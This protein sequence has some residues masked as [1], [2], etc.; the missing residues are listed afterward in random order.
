MTSSVNNQGLVKKLR[1]DVSQCRP[2]DQNGRD[3]REDAEGGNNKNQ[4]R[5]F[6]G[7]H[8][9]ALSLRFHDVLLCVKFF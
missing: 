1:P 8:E 6:Y 4:V 9:A 7:I 2:R 3:E 5:A